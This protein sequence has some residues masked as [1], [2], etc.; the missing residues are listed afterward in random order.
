MQYILLN[1]IPGNLQYAV[2]GWWLAGTIWTKKPKDLPFLYGETD[3]GKS[4]EKAETNQSGS[5]HDVFQ[6]N[7]HW[8]ENKPLFGV[9]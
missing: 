5:I 4:D 1:I 2:H 9:P 6:I 8:R 7:D 3:D